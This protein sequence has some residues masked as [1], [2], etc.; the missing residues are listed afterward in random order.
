M[1]G[2]GWDVGRLDQ[3]SV[4]RLKRGENLEL[5]SVATELAPLRACALRGRGLGDLPLDQLLCRLDLRA[6]GVAPEGYVLLGEG[7]GQLGR[8]RRAWVR[9]GNGCDVRL[10]LRGHGDVVQDILAG[11]PRVKLACGSVGDDLQ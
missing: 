3:L 8:E 4:A 2:D 7:V 11:E 9:G 10:A 1:R 6:I 5:L